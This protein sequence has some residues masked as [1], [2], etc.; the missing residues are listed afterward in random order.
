VLLFDEELDEAFDVW[1]F[2][3][4]VAFGGIGGLDVGFE[5]EEAG[6]GEGPIV[7]D[8]E[9]LLVGLDVGDYAFEV[10]VVADQFE[11]GGGANA[12]DGVEVIAAEEDAEIDELDMSVLCR[13]Q[14]QGH[15]LPAPA[16]CRDPP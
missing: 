16:P 8:G 9:L 4:E 13:S 3:F 5:E 7:G 2:P 11:G 1:G 10:L 15:V 12:F 6:V 14:K